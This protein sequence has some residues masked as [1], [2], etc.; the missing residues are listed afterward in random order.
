MNNF[1]ILMTIL[2]FSLAATAKDALKAAPQVA[3]TGGAFRSY[4]RVGITEGRPLKSEDGD[5]YA[6]SFYSKSVNGI[7]VIASVA[8]T[9]FSPSTVVTIKYQPDPNKPAIEASGRGWVRFETE[10]AQINCHASYGE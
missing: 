6:G 4:T 5:E 7:Q 8:L 2:G 1:L 3:C 9:E 10:A